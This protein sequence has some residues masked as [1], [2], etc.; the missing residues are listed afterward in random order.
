MAD[1]ESGARDAADMLQLGVSMGMLNPEQVESV[2]AL[3]MQMRRSGINL[4]VG[5]TLLER[6]YISLLQ[7]KDLRRELSRRAEATRQAAPAAPA[8]D[9]VTKK[10]GQYEIIKVLSEKDRARVFQARDTMMNRVVVLKVLPRSMTSDPQWAERFRREIILAGK[11]AHPNIATVYGAGEVD[12]NPLMTIEYIEGMSL[13]ERLER[14][15]NM[16]EKVAWRTAREVAKG[17]AFAASNGVVHRDIKPDNV[18]CSID[19][20]IKIIDMGLSKSEGDVSGLTLDGTTVGTP[21]YISPEQA[22]GTRDVD[23]RSD[24]YSLGC[25]VFHMLTGS[26]PFFHEEFTEVMRRQAQAPRPD[27]RD[28]LPEISE[29]SAKLVMRMMAISPADRPE[30]FEALIAEI[31]ALMPE[32]PEPL[33]DVRPVAQVSSSDEELKD[34]HDQFWAPPAPGQVPTGQGQGHSRKNMSPAAPPKSYSPTPKTS[35]FGNRSDTPPK[36]SIFGRLASWFDS[37]FR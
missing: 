2:S 20:K 6:K 22:R 10:F 9:L 13:G 19:G 36:S 23:S 37:L 28:V 33:A 15:G 17:L 5:Q 29:A 27:P 31:D 3:Q 4:P 30:S 35:A 12:G 21:F 8:K 25:T 18:L 34:K 16:P 26:V 14:E 32:L 7:L 24:L 11:L 1:K